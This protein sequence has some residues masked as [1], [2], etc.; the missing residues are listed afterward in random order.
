MGARCVPSQGLNPTLV[1][2]AGEIRVWLDPV[3]L[4]RS[5]VLSGFGQVWLPGKPAGV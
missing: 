4:E 5:V 1:I 3:L 2:A